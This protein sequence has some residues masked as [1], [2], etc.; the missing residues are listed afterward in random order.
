MLHNSSDIGLRIKQSWHNAVASD[1][2][3]IGPTDERK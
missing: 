2:R 3:T 1:Y